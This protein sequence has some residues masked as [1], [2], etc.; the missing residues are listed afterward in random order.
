L[1]PSGKV[2]RL[3]DDR[4]LLGRSCSDQVA[5]YNKAGRDPDP[6]LQ[7]RTSI[8][9]DL[10]NCLNKIEPGANCPLSIMFMRLGVTE[11]GENAVAHVFCDKPRRSAPP[12]LA[13]PSRSRRAIQRRM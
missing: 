9:G 11:I 3:S 5:D 10:W 13:G 4:L 12:S 2:R 7:G 6:N 8:R 1:E